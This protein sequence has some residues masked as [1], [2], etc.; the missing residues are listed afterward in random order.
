MCYFGDFPSYVARTNDQYTY[1]GGSN[2]YFS[3]DGGTNHNSQVW[4]FVSNPDLHPMKVTVNTNK[5]GTAPGY[6]FVGPYEY[7]NTPTIGQTGALI[8]DQSGNPIWF[9]Q[10]DKYTQNR[11]FK[12][13]YYFG[14]PVLTLWQGTIAGTLFA[15]PIHPQGEPLPGGYFQIIN[16]HYQVIRTITAREGYTADNHEFLITKRN[17]ALFLAI[18]HVPADLAQYGGPKE[19]YIRNYSIQE[20]ELKTD[21]L[22][23]F[24]D[25]LSHINPAYSNV[26]APSAMEVHHI[27]DP[28]HLNS[29]EDGPNDTLL[30]SMRDMWSIY[31]INKKTGNIIWQLGGKQSDFTFGPNATFSWQHDARYRSETKISL[32]DNACCKSPTTLPEEAS[33]G[34]IVD[35]D[36]KNMTVTGHRTYYHS[37]AL[38]VDHQGNMQQLPN[39]NQFVGWGVK[40]YLSEFK[41]GGNTKEKP[42]ENLVYGMQM[43]NHTYRAFKYEWVGLPID[44]PDIAIDFLRNGKVIVYAS[45]NGSTE[46]TAWQVLAGS[47]PY[48]MLNTVPCTPRTGFETAIYPDVNGPYFQVHALNSY[49]VIIGRS[50]LTV[51]H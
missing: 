34:L 35:L 46:T 9:R 38:Y 13:Q 12:V 4:E 37:P 42:S 32:F 2:N 20:I 36:Y 29:V 6:I 50:R 51:V 17:T 43:P 27:W 48:T 25:A 21:K 18:K 1:H 30:V 16:Q 22:I 40:P 8:M 5:P 3:C 10:S 24:W 47:T 15:N 45:W 19:G 7:Y 33:H 44:P 14:H 26:P 23:F 11:D 41:Y 28:F 31:N 49:G 39:Y